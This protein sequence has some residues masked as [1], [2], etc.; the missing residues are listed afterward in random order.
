MPN[1]LNAIK[2]DFVL[3]VLLIVLVVSVTCAVM[4]GTSSL[5]GIGFIYLS[6][7]VL[8][9]I[10][11]RRWDSLKR[12][13]V[14]TGGSVV[15]FFLCLLLYNVI[16][17]I[18]IQWFGADFWDKTLTGDEFFFFSI[19]VFICPVTFIIGVAGSISTAVKNRKESRLAS[20]S[21]GMRSMDVIPAPSRARGRS[22]PR[23]LMLL[24]HSPR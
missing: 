19:A 23:W 13:L 3:I 21:G 12:Y 2:N 8:S 11:T 15:V 6:V 16:H 22:M 5:A 10:I 1:R 17:R 4:Q 7:A 14:L 9:A 24:R 20:T 18:L